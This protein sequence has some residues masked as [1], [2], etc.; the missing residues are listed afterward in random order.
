M[1]FLYVAL[2][3]LVLSSFRR[4]NKGVHWNNDYIS[5]E[6]SNVVKGICIWLVF[7]CHISQYMVAIPSLNYADKLCFDINSSLKQLLVVP[8]LFYSGYGVTLSII[9][10]G[11]AYAKM[12]PKK[13][14]WTT[15]LN[16][17]IA[18]LFF[19][20]MN[21]ALGLELNYKQVLL[22]FVG[23]DS[24]RNSN[25]YIF[26]IIICYLISWLAYLFAKNNKNMLFTIWIGIFFYTAVMYFFKG[27]W[28]YDTIYAYGTGAVFAI[29]NDKILNLIKRY[30][31][32]SLL[33]AIVGFLMFYN[34]P[35]YFSIAANVCAVFLCLL[36]VLFTLKVKLESAILAW[37]GKLLFPIY[38]YQRLPMVVLSTISGGTLMYEFKYLYIISCLAITLLIAVLYK[39]K[40]KL[41]LSKLVSC[42]TKA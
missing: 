9:E 2:L 39:N 34:L 40:G 22:A 16:F 18:V 4:L 41:Y 33:T 20:I 31:K 24:I 6:T 38:I 23:W 5:I 30:Y 7:I 29:Y 42:L 17:D 36:I 25:W 28:W 1:I 15:L 26:C 10:K 21:L 19:L 14:V 37:S 8:F 12:I 11:A 32:V 3:L 35:N 27:H 13:R